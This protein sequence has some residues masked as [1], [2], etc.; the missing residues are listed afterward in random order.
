MAPSRDRRPGFSRRAQYGLFVTYVLGIAGA[1]VGAVLLALSTF[2]PAAFQVAQAA[3]AE[4]QTADALIA[5][6]ERAGVVPFTPEGIC[7][8]PVVM[9]AAT[10]TYRQAGLVQTAAQ[11]KK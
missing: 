2:R 3:V 10:A 7:A 6:A 11:G 4:P 1:V 9:A 8:A 5:L